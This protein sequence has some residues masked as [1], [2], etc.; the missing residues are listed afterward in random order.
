MNQTDALEI[1]QQAI[2]VTMVASGPIVIAAMAVGIVIAV[3]QALTQIQEMTLTFV[4]KILIGCGIAAVTGPYIGTVLRVFT[5]ELYL[6]I[7]TGF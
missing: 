1:L 5:E 7:E 4:P 6:H 3:I 2:W